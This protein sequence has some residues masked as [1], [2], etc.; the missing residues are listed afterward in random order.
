MKI[1]IIDRNHLM[2]VA[3]ENETIEYSNHTGLFIDNKQ[4]FVCNSEPSSSAY[5]IER[6]KDDDDTLFNTVLDITD[7]DFTTDELL[8]LYLEMDSLIYPVVLPCYDHGKLMYDIATMVG[9]FTNDCNYYTDIYRTFPIVLYYGFRL[10]LSILDINAAIKYW[11][12]IH[13][14]VVEK[15]KCNCN[16]H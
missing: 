7:S 10:A 12:R 1:Q 14:F 3:S 16:G 13:N 11:D 5:Y 15:H 9:I 8:I 6:G 2:I 4:S